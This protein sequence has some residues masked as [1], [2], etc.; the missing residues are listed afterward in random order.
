M[1]FKF[2]LILPIV[3]TIFVTSAFADDQV[4]GMVASVEGDPYYFSD[5]GFGIS[6]LKDGTKVRISKKSGEAI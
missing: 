6:I 1:N 4:P 2:Y 3:F 5:G